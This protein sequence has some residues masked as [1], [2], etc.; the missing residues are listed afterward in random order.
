[1]VDFQPAPDSRM[2]PS[3]PAALSP[4]TLVE[5]LRWR[6]AT[7]KFDPAR[8][9]PAA[10]W[11]AIEQALLLAPSSYGL[12]P[13]KFFVVDDRALREQLM[14]ASWNQRQVVD[15]SHYVV[16]AARTSIERRDGE[17]WVARLAEVRG[18]PVESLAGLAKGLAKFADTPPARVRHDAWSAKQTYIALGFAL[19][20]A[21]LLGIDTVAMEGFD[22]ARY[23]ALLGLAE[24]GYTAVCGLALGYRAADDLNASLPKAR[25]PLAQVVEHL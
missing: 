19:E 10:E 24:R 11:A 7:K 5:R 6:Y 8:K 9:I 1:M 13:W 2:N 21:A 17:R 25:F 4:E 16:L 23:D 20:S 15:A 14:A 22:P 12:Q 3:T 18:V